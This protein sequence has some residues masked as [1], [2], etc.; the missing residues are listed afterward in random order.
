[1]ARGSMSRGR[2][3]AIA[4]ALAVGAVGVPA[5]LG[6][7]VVFG[8]EAEAAAPIAA[9]PAQNPELTVSLSLP[10]Q[11]TQGDTVAATVTISN[12]SPRFQTIAVKGIWVD[13]TGEATITSK[14]GILLPGQ[15]ITRVIDYVVNEKCV[16]GIHELTVSV[17]GRA[18]E[19]S[20][21][22]AV[23]VI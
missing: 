7:P 13:P 17:E 3:L 12:N 1:M 4:V 5:T 9:A 16:P 6:A 21:T 20:A 18:G 10:P 15:T 19:S 23:E 14:S 22:A 2:F 11:A 8:E